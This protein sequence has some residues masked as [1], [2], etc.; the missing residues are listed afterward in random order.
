MRATSRQ[1]SAQ[2]SALSYSMALSRARYANA[3]E[4]EKARAAR[5]SAEYARL[6]PLLAAAG[7]GP[8]GGA[9]RLRAEARAVR[10]RSGAAR[11]SERVECAACTAVGATEAE[12]FAIHHPELLP[13][14]ETMQEAIDQAERRGHGRYAEIRR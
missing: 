10:A 1:R 11:R 4:A 5:A 8:H 12:A 6:Q 7:Y 9:A 2:V 14:T 13:S 3:V